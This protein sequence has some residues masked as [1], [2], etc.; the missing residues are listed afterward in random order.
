[1]VRGICLH[2]LVILTKGKDLFVDKRCFTS[3]NMT[4]DDD[5][6]TNSPTIFNSLYEP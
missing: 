4:K 6:Q 2:I 1:M 3:F 5:I